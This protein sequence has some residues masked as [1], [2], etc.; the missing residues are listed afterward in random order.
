MKF[1]FR[2]TTNQFHNDKSIIYL[3]N[4]A[5]DSQEDIILDSIISV[6]E[7]SNEEDRCEYLSKIKEYYLN[8]GMIFDVQ[9]FD[10]NVDNFLSKNIGNMKGTFLE[11]LIY[12]LIKEYCSY[13]EIY[14]ECKV[15]YNNADENNH[16]YDFITQNNIIK[17]MDIKFSCHHLKPSHLNYLVEYLDEENVESYLISLDTFSKIENKINFLKFKNEISEEECEFFKNNLQFITNREIYEAVLDKKCLT[18]LGRFNY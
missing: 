8:K 13:D 1:Q 3:S 14:K 4:L 9:E 7:M 18:N 5:F 6:F 17:F 12:K 16:P 10:E 2:Q 15:T 11:L